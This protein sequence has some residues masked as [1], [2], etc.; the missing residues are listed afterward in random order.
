[1]NA[2]AGWREVFFAAAAALA[3]VALAATVL[4]RN[5]PRD[6][7][8]PEPPVSVTNVFGA[9]GA[10][11]RPRGVRDLVVPYM[12]SPAFWL[13]CAVSLGLT[14]VREAF[15]VW[16]PTYLVEVYGYSDG[17]AAQRSALVPLMGGFSALL[18]GA[19]SDRLAVHNRLLVALPLLA[20]AI[21]ALVGVATSSASDP[22]VG[23]LLLGACA[24]LLIGPYTLLA[25][26]MAVDLG[27]RRGAAT[28]V[29]LIDTAG[30]LGAVLSGYA[31][32][33]VAQ[34]HGWTAVFWLLAIVTALSTAACAA[35]CWRQVR[36]G[37]TQEA[38]H[39]C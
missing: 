3:A 32:G 35:Q 15:N 30:Y 7:G 21:V 10:E 25:G 14:L 17:D 8:L 38:S 16:T 23:L 39:A 34:T 18:V 2:G 29:G 24:F 37:M 12:R 13:V 22:R 26:A 27:G 1:V 6:I 33:T 31:V 28:A 20:G 19:L 11:S 36:S 4:L 5:S 9:V